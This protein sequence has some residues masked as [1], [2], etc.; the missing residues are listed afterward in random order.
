LSFKLIALNP[1]ID[2]EQAWNIQSILIKLGTY[3]VL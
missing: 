3:L 1:S 2:F